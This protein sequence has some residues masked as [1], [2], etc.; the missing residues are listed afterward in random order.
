MIRD[1]EWSCVCAGGLD[2]ARGYAAG[3]MRQVAE[4]ELEGRIRFVGEHDETR[5]DALYDESSLFVSASH[6]EGYGMALAEALAR[7]LPIVS[8]T[9]GAIPFTV[10]A[11]AG[12]LVEPGDHGALAYALRELLGGP[13]GARSTPCGASGRLDALA[14]AAR[15]HGLELPEWGESIRAFARAVV[16]LAPE[17]P[18]R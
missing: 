11:D 6:Y 4:A 13:R 10:P 5:L 12:V 1:L 8:T 9:G 15:R 2:R 18:G 16:E 17:E 7:G 14:V 3:V